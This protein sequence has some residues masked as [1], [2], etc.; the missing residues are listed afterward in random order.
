M[1]QAASSATVRSLRGS[2][3]RYQVSPVPRQSGIK[4]TAE[5]SCRGRPAATTSERG[6][7]GS[8][9]NAGGVSF[10]T[11]KYG[12]QDRHTRQ[13]E[14]S[15]DI[16]IDDLRATVEAHRATNI[17]SILRKVASDAPPNLDIK[18]IHV[19]HPS[20]EHAVESLQKSG[21]PVDQEPIDA[22]G[23]K[24]TKLKWRLRPKVA[25]EKGL[26]A[27]KKRQARELRSRRNN[28]QDYEGKS[29][30]PVDQWALKRDLSC[31]DRP[32]LTYL[33]SYEEDG[34]SHAFESYM[35]PTP[36]ETSAVQSAVDLVQKIVTSALPS[37]ALSLFGSRYT[38]LA[39]PLSDVDFNLSLPEF[40]GDTSIRGPSNTRPEACRAGMRVLKRLGRVLSSN[41]Q[42]SNVKIIPA[43]I[44]L[45]TATHHATGVAFQF[46]T[47]ARTLPSREWTSDYVSEYPSL[48]PLFL[49]L[50][51]S[52]KIRGLVTVQFG[53]LGSYPLA[54]MIVAALKHAAASFS[55]DDLA[56][57]LIHILDFYANADLYK[58][59]FS[60]DPFR[61]FTKITK[62]LSAEE[63]EANSRD[64]YL[65]SIDLI[66]KCHPDKPWALCLQDP[67]DPVND[68]GRKTYQIKHVQASFAAARQ[69]IWSRVQRWDRMDIKTRQ[70]W[71]QGLLDPL[72]RARYDEF[73]ASR[74][75]LARSIES[76]LSK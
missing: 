76:R 53:G 64:P 24:G 5:I 60:A 31:S 3:I 63:R 50:R 65:W 23:T 73:E 68:L 29:L 47:L 40:K 22:E 21:V 30:G 58:H 38:G 18:K 56:G 27:R 43:R 28:G 37:N 32:W 57:Q 14:N 19:P 9:A 13:H 11:R 33:Q 66:R 51:H 17:A 2:L 16:I 4:P 12:Y 48:R 7:A 1:P 10:L 41:G 39:G 45:L 49:L 52:L 74:Q 55:R 8:A 62:P 42:F 15:R 36:T 70:T 34:Q 69:R 25:R 35:R 26:A 61:M 6:Q 72:V 59:G 20:A 46:Q 54:M 71:A 44:P 67:A 75:V